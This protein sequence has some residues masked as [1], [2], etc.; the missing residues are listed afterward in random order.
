MEIGTEEVDVLLFYQVAGQLMGILSIMPSQGKQVELEEAAG[1]LQRIVP[2]LF[3]AKIEIAFGMGEDGLITFHLEIE[4]DLH[5][6]EHGYDK[7]E[8]NQHPIA[9]KG[10]Q[11]LAVFQGR[12]EFVVQQVFCGRLDLDIDVLFFIAFR[13]AAR[14]DPIISGVLGK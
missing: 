14:P 7:R 9:M 2:S 12:A 8:L 5:D 11:G 4:K 10:Q 1:I 3:G 13:T 6:V